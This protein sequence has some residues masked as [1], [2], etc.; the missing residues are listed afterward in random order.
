MDTPTTPQP[1]LFDP[2]QGGAQGTSADNSSPAPT[3]SYGAWP[4]TS[5]QP[6]VT[7]SVTPFA[8]MPRSAASEAAPSADSTIPQ[9]AAPANVPAN[10]QAP[11]PS[12]WGVQNWQPVNYGGYGVYGGWQPYVPVTD[13]QPPRRRTPW[14]ALLVVVLLALLIGGAAGAGITH[15]LAAGTSAGSGQVVSLG[16]SSAP[17]V[18]VS[19]GTTTLQQD[20]EA[21]AAAVE[22]SVV[23]ITAILPNGESVGSGDILTANGYIVTNDHV[24]QGGSSFT[25]RLATGQSYQA[26]LVGQ[27]AADDLAVVKINA[28]N[29]KPI[30]F[31][32]SSQVQVGE[33]AI[34]VGN[35]LDLG[36]AA[37]LGTV[38]G[39]NGSASEA[40][41]GGPAGQLTG[42]IQTTAIINPGN[43]GGALVNLQGQLIGIPTLEEQNPDTRSASG[44]G[45]A[46]SSNQVQ[47]IAQQLIKQGHV[48][49][50]DKGFIG[51]EAQDTQGG[52]L[53]AGFAAD[54]AGISPAQQ[55]GLQQGDVITAIDGQSVSDQNELA[56]AVAGRAPGA[57]VTITVQRGS[58]QVTVTLT[59][60]QRPPNA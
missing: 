42:L 15:L 11:E 55:A 39:I 56:A 44:L 30:A 52:V 20:S 36:E 4:E 26:T 59:L 12:S 25:V 49:A 34:A 57:K 43:S 40:A 14:G 9:T 32:N 58:S 33:F 29:L 47:S 7:P 17:N 16:S 41:D 46:I 60:G 6:P 19:S 24:V 38:S 13:A 22:P 8:V 54:A 27:D 35:P 37:T 53:I 3:P 48:T 31:A 21:V 23:K 45:Y 18:S 2:S 1:P 51:I 5:Y 50:T 10:F 28:T